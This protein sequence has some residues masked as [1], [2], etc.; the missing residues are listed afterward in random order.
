MP[1][2]EFDV[3]LSAAS[4][5]AAQARAVAQALPDKGMRVW[6]YEQDVPEHQSISRA[7]ATGLARSN[8]LLAYY[9]AS[10]PTSRACQW[11][12]TTALVAA[13]QEGNP[14]RRILVANPEPTP[15]HIEPV[16]L[17]DARYQKASA[18]GDAE[19]RQRFAEAVQEH[20]A[21]ITTAFADVQPLDAVPWFGTIGL[22]SQRFVGRLRE[23][24]R[25]HSALHAAEFAPVTGASGPGVVQIRGL[26]GVGKSLLAEEYA[27]RFGCAYPGGIF[28]LRAPEPEAT[29]QATTPEAL[30][31]ARFRQYRSYCEA[32]GVGTG[33]EE[34]ERSV[35][36]L[37]RE[38]ERRARPFL[39]VVDDLPAKLDA[40]EFRKWLAPSPI[41]KTIITTKSRE[42]EALSRTIDVGGLE[43]DDAYALLT[44][45][46]API[47]QAE[48]ESARGIVTLLGHHPLA[49]DVS[50]A[51][52]ATGSGLQSFW[53]YQEGLSS[54]GTDELEFASELAGALPTGHEP[55][56]ARTLLRTVQQV[57]DEG[58]GLLRLGSLV[59]AAPLPVRFVETVFEEVDRLDRDTARRRAIRALH[60]CEGL[61]LIERAGGEDQAFTVHALTARAVRF[62]EV[63]N[64]RRT[65][66][67][68]ATVRVLA[69]ALGHAPNPKSHATLSQ[70]A[71][72]AATLCLDANSA[73]DASLLDGLAQF[74]FERAAFASA[75]SLRRRHVDLLRRLLSEAD[76]RLLDAENRLA[77]VLHLVGQLGEARHVEEMALAR[78]RSVLGDAHEQTLTAKHNLAEILATTGDSA[79]AR[80]LYEEVLLAREAMLGPGHPNILVT[81]NNL[82]LLY[83]RAGDLDEAVRLQ[84]EVVDGEQRTFGERHARTLTAKMNL[85]LTLL[86][87]NELQA[88][89]ELCEEVTATAASAYGETHTLTLG[90]QRGLA[91]VLG[92]QGRMK[93]ASELM[94]HVVTGLEGVWPASHPM[95]LGAKRDLAEFL[96]Q[97]GDRATAT[98]I[99]LEVIAGLETQDLVP[100]QEINAGKLQL[101]QML[102]VSDRGRAKAIVEEVIASLGQD[103]GAPVDQLAFAKS[104]LGEIALSEGRHEAAILLCEEALELYQRLHGLIHEQTILAKGN[105]AAAVR[106]VGDLARAAGLWAEVEEAARTHLGPQH[107]L[108]VD[109]KGALAHTRAQNR[110]PRRS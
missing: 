62:S 11:E 42:Y 55:S 16:Q 103:P 51:A 47:G 18:L 78:A 25:F 5:D 107:P 91:Q 26:G 54:P 105:L 17:R 77:R 7:I 102:L 40:V 58:Q 65:V 61:S 60:Q 53:D 30:E 19:S 74:D 95:L 27:L 85:A 83:Q 31:A 110:R 101:A 73:E 41:G 69:R 97:A 43:P 22:G 75:E 48:I 2:P 96:A 80:S 45:R 38:L 87:R 10:Y 67:R 24:W 35:A 23:L 9:S 50:G 79:S 39:W 14:A 66:L 88:A 36:L 70:L 106:E 94:R 82:A 59:D 72:H 76:E 28:W 86:G 63:D 34:G 90:A 13:E 100:V 98:R 46:R 104:V 71:P 108:A 37:R 12:L 68:G 44:S 57:R 99:Q 52:L 15:H 1:N 109:A 4:K 6:Y 56:I 29:G 81:K 3:F 89:Q 84:R 92:A 64:A 33:S 49:L 32:L 20:V 8:A 93:E 21:P